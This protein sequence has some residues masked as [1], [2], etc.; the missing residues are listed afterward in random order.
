MRS[1]G[2]YISLPYFTN[3][4]SLKVIHV[5]VWVKS[6]SFGCYGLAHCLCSPQ[7]IHLPA[8]GHLDYLQ[9]LIIT[10]KLALN[11]WV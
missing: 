5:V 4:N 6:H 7:F 3:H 8:D 11:I 2:I 9:F 10:N 1:Y